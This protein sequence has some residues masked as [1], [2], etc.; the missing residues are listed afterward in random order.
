MVA[1]AVF[2]VV[3]VLLV[4][5]V[6]RRRRTRKHDLESSKSRNRPIRLHDLPSLARQ[7]LRHNEHL[8]WPLITPTSTH[9]FGE[10][11]RAYAANSRD[12]SIMFEREHDRVPGTLARSLSRT[13]RLIRERI[14]ITG[15][16]DL[17]ISATPKICR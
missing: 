2:A 9:R 8:A 1:G 6:I 5:V 14:R 12:N 15:R 3:A 13:E 17:P 4:C 16:P 11:I 10:T 7:P